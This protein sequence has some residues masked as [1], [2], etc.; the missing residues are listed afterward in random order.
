M[1]RS[2]DR[3]GPFIN[4]FFFA[5]IFSMTSTFNDEAGNGSS[6]TEFVLSYLTHSPELQLPVFYLFLTIY[7]FTVVGN[8]QLITWLSS[9]VICTPHL[10]PPCTISSSTSPSWISV[11]LFFSVPK[12]WYTLSL[13]R[14]ASPMRDA[15]LSSISLS[16]FSSLNAT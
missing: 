10:K 7:I 4:K 1:I 12:C 15:W 11:M 8:F 5:S 2:W 9:I 14:I 16:F 3:A 6:V 13:R